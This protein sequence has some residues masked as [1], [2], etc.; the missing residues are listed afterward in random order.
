M[1]LEVDIHSSWR[2]LPSVY[3]HVDMEDKGTIQTSMFALKTALMSED[4]PEP[5]CDQEWYR[6]DIGLV[7]RRV[8]VPFPPQES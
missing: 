4:F 2:C 5:L 6:F 3:S 8:N 7:R 1:D